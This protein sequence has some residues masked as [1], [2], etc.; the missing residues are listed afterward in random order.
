[1][2]VRGTHP[3]DRHPGGGGQVAEDVRA[4]LDVLTSICEQLPD[5]SLDPLLGLS[6]VDQRTDQRI[7][8]RLPTDP[9]LIGEE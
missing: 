8:L 7:K 6:G 9:Q 3:R 4:R 1:M 2:A 5:L